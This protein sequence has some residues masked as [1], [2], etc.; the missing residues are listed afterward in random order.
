MGAQLAEGGENHEFTGAGAGHDGFVLELPG[1][2]MWDVHGIQTDLHG[3]ID[4][5]AGA[6]ANHPPMG[7][8]DFVLLYQGAVHVRAFLGNNFDKLKKTL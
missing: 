4:V 2:L 6:V 8:H 1:V 3:G 7:L 5:A